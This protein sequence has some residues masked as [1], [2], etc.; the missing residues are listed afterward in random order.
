[1]VDSAAAVFVAQANNLI[2][3]F[4]ASEVLP[5]S[6]FQVISYMYEAKSYLWIRIGHF[7]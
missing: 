2:S 4:L 5:L 1:M 6:T 7:A 3:D